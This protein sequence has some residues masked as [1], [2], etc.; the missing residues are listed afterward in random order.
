M[1]R[2]A[3]TLRQRLRYAFDN[4][5]SKG[6]PALIGWL[7]SASVLFVAGTAALVKLTGTAPVDGG[8]PAPLSFSGQMWNNLMRAMDS[9]TMGG[10]NGSPLYLALMLVVTLGGVFIVG[11]LIGLISNG[12]GNQIDELRKGRGLV[13]ETDHIVILGWSP[14]IFA[15]V[16]ELVLG[17]EHRKGNCIA[18]L[19]DRDKVEME[20]ELRDR[21]TDLKTTRIALL[22]VLWTVSFSSLFLMICEVLGLLV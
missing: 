4:T 16:G 3:F 18:I 10:D 19:A 7:A 1:T 12:V 2:P 11:T 5:L 9:G 22:I 21:I 20:D 13:A 15:V 14:Q 8:A 17:N 6:T